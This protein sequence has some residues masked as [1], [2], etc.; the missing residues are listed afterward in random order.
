MTMKVRRSNS[1]RG[2][3]TGF[4]FSQNEH[5]S[6]LCGYAETFGIGLGGRSPIH[7]IQATLWSKHWGPLHPFVIQ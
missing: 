1:C 5:G 2:R 6:G 7:L 4:I 3:V